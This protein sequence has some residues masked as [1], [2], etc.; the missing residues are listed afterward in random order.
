MNDVSQMKEVN[1]FENVFTYLHKASLPQFYCEYTLITYSLKIRHLQDNN[2]PISLPP[3]VPSNHPLLLLLPDN[4]VN[5]HDIIRRIL[6]LTYRDM[7]LRPLTH[8]TPNSILSCLPNLYSDNCVLDDYFNLLCFKFPHVSYHMSTDFTQYVYAI[9]GNADKK[10]TNPNI[11]TKHS[12]PTNFSSENVK[13]IFLPIF[14]SHGSNKGHNVLVVLLTTIIPNMNN[15]I[16]YIN[17]K[18]QNTMFL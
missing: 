13:V 14:E 7:F 3:P 2:M 4:Y 17:S 11:F 15:E 12:S 8:S 6:N 5:S 16:L 10:Y 1:N 9:A 18:K